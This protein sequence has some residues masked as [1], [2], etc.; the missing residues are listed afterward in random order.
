MYCPGL[1]GVKGNNCLPESREMNFARIK[2]N[3]W[4]DRLA[5][6]AT[7]ANNLQDLG[8]SEVLNWKHN[9]WAQSQGHH[10]ID[11]LK[12]R[13]IVF[14]QKHRKR[15]RLMIIF[16]RAIVNHMNIGTVWKAVLWK[17]LKNM[18]ERMYGF[19]L[20]VNTICLFLC[21]CVNTISLSLSLSLSLIQSLCSSFDV[22]RAS[23][24]Q[25]LQAQWQ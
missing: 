25:I 24:V 5:G 2:G 20:C 9:L 12:E 13:E 19:F 14:T 7:I 22:T 11:H 10:T 17:L 18:A 23:T 8:S 4:A 6:K 21:F 15:K 1:A 3:N 16:E